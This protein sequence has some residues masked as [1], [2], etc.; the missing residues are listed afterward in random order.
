VEIGATWRTCRREEFDFLKNGEVFMPISKSALIA[1]KRRR[2][3]LTE[4]YNSGYRKEIIKVRA[5]PPPESGEQWLYKP[6]RILGWEVADY[7]R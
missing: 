5:E 7:R 4:E 6:E 2:K 1:S 3:T